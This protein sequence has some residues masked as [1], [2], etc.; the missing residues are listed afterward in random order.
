MDDVVQRFLQ[1]IRLELNQSEHTVTAYGHDLKQFTG[2][3]TSDGH[4]RLD[5]GSVTQSD[6][7]AWLVSLSHDGDGPRTL[8]RKVQAVRALYKW[9]MWRGEAEANPAADV[10]LAKLP[11]QL[12][13]TIRVQNMDQLLDSPVD[14]ADHDEV[15]NRLI[16]MM[17]YE[18]GMRRAELIGLQDAWV[19]TTACELRVHG[20]RDKDR[21][22]PFGHELAEWIGI[23]RNLR[24]EAYGRCD[25]FF[26]RRDGLPLYPSLV[27]KVVHEALESVGGGDKLSP[28]VLRHTFASAMLND[29]AEINSVKEILGHESLAATQVYTHVT[30]NELRN[31]YKLAH[32]RALKKGG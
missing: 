1:Y 6:V 26:V 25:T 4:R 27:Y 17:L 29:G 5:L 16:V 18:T 24:S 13:H 21:I 14:M 7:R 9:L 20:K 32:P 19:D 28:H 31:N 30:F 22:I 3:L 23:Y 10:E 8:R 11:K 2:F 15:R 12:P